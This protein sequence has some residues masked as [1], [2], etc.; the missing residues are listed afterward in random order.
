LAEAGADGVVV[1]VGAVGE[2]VVA[3][4]HAAVG[5]AALPGGELRCETVGEASFDELDGAL[6][7]DVGGGEEQVDVVG[8]EDEGV[9][10]VVACAAVVL[11]GFEEEFGGG[12][13]L[14]ESA[15]VVGL[16]GNEEGSWLVALVGIAIDG[17]AYLSG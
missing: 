4:A 3:V 7:G 17:Q 11:E 6:E 12:C 14:E 9:E 13:D 10:L 15:P 8:H 1:D 2:E 16:G 5:E